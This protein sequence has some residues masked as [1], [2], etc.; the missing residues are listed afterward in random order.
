MMMKK[1]AG[2]LHTFRIG[3]HSR[4]NSELKTRLL[5]RSTKPMEK[6]HEW[7]RTGS[8]RDY[9]KQYQALMREIQDMC[10]GNRLLNLIPKFK[11]LARN[12]FR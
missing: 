12:E 11:D 8:L 3:S 9:I 4:R 5:K 6:L 2:A 10:E 7:K 1:R